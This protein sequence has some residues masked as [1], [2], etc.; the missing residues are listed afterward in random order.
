[1]SHTAANRRYD[2]QGQENDGEDRLDLLN[3]RCLEKD[4]PLMPPEP[5][6][7]RF[8]SLFAW[9][10]LAHLVCCGVPLLILGVGGA[11]LT[12]GIVWPVAPYVGLGLALAI[13]GG[14][15]W[16]LHR[17]RRVCP[18]CAVSTPEQQRPAA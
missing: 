11:G 3:G 6:R 18:T 7:R 10:M 17:R 12:A 14:L 15:V 5:H 8:R 2:E 1:L 16:Y 13:A 4:V 9:T